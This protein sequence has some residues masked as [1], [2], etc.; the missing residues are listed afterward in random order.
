MF[1]TIEWSDEGVVMIDQRLL[2]NREEYITLKS[3]GD[4][5]WA[6]KD[7]VIRGAP[8]IGVAAAMGVAL[9]AHQARDGSSEEMEEAFE[10]ASREI[11]ATRP[12]AV[13]LFWALTRMRAL[14]HQ[15]RQPVDA[16]PE[17]HRVAH[18]Q[19]L[20]DVLEPQ[21]ACRS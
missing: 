9:A 11:G 14:F 20:A 13:N 18:Q 1:K 8:A 3:P 4:V 6:I 17:V 21:R 7:M 19:H 15:N 5:A 10:S 2:P 16:L 12:T